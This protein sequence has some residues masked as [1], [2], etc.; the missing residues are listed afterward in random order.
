MVVWRR[1]RG[2]AFRSAAVSRAPQGLDIPHCILETSAPSLHAL[3]FVSTPHPASP[4]SCSS[5]P[6]PAGRTHWQSTRST[7]PLDVRQNARSR[8]HVLSPLPF[9]LLTSADARADFTSY[10]VRTTIAG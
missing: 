4:H 2:R 10:P 6:S 8:Q 5:L 1:L 7:R 3:C 9:F